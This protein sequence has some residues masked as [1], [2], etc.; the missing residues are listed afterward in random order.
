MR[1]SKYQIGQKYIE[2]GKSKSEKTV[3]DILYTFNSK[4]ELV[5][6]EYL[7]EYVFCGDIIHQ[8]ISEL[9]LDRAKSDKRLLN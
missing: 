9:T 6:M 3:I 2:Q 1:K 8:T 7:V 5:K 4:K